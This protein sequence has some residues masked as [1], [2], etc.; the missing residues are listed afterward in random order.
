MKQIY[1][2]TTEKIYLKIY[3]DGVPVNSTGAVTYSLSVVGSTA[4]PRTG[5]ASSDATGSYYVYTLL[6]ETLLEGSLKVDWAF[7]VGSDLG[8]RTDYISIVTPYAQFIDIK[9]LAPVGTSDTEIENAEMFAR[10]NINA[11]T[12]QRFGMRA[13]SVKMH[14]NDQSTLVL[15]H[16]IVTLDKITIND[17]D[18]WTRSPETNNFGKTVTVSDTNYGLLATKYDDVPVWSDF[19]TWPAWKKS[20]W[21]VFGGVYGWSQVPDEVE[22]CAR[23]LADDYFCKETG[24]KKRFVEQINASDWR[25]VFNQKQFTG[26][27]NYFA[28]QILARY[29]SIGMVLI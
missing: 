5:A 19:P 26:T 15:P 29:K 24:W 18:V 17:E 14:G 28:D 20:T 21:Y 3:Q 1:T 16:R 10:Y 6:P 22:Y 2:N 4:A 11:F 12:G 8:S 27:G 9:E 23:L 13:D 7:S 25:I